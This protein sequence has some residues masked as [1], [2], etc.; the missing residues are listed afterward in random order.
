MTVKLLSMK[1]SFFWVLGIVVRVEVQVFLLI[2]IYFIV[3][4]KETSDAGCF[5]RIL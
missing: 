2:A 1:L 5:L 4:G 3:L